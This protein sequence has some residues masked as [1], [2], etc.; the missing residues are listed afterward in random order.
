M[1]F[2]L[3]ASGVFLSSTTQAFRISDQDFGLAL[4]PFSDTGEDIIPS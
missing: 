2:F 1:A 4:E 3:L